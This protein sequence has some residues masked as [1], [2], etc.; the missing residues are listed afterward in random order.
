MGIA[1]S[2]QRQEFFLRVIVVKLAIV[3]REEMSNVT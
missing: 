3:D 2:P 1:A